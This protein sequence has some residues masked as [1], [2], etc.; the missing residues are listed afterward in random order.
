M[1]H[2]AALVGWAADAAP[3]LGRCEPLL[4]ASLI[5]ASRQRARNSVASTCDVLGTVSRLSGARNR[6]H[7]SRRR[8][9]RREWN[10][11]Q[12]VRARHRDV[13]GC[14]CWPN[15][16]WVRPCK[17]PGQRRCSGARRGLRGLRRI[18]A[19]ESGER[20]EEH[21]ARTPR[22]LSCVLA[23]GIPRAQLPFCTMDKY[24]FPKHRNSHV[25]SNALGE[26]CR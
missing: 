7:G 14:T 24:W 3:E 2:H 8:H 6:T 25:C 17:L 16:S 20:R 22:D 26:K 18:S 10:L 1:P 15:G 5:G 23:S 21:L 9:W 12:A 11:A 13:P 4:R 19:L